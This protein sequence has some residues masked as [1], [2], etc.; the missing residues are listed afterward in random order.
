MSIIFGGAQVAGLV[1]TASAGNSTSSGAMIAILTGQIIM[2][3]PFFFIITL[4]TKFGGG[5]LDKVAGNIASRGKG[6][7]GGASNASN[8]EGKA[9]L[10]RGFERA[11][12][13]GAK[14][15]KNGKEKVGSS[16]RRGLIGGLGRRYDQQRD[17]E[18]S[19]DGYLKELRGKA[20]TD[21]LAS[22]SDY[23][24]KSAAGSVSDGQLLRD[25]AVASA[26]AGELKKALEPLSRAI[27]AARTQ[28][29]PQAM[30]KLLYDQAI[31]GSTQAEKSAAMHE[32]SRLGRDE[33]V[34]ALRTNSGFADRLPPVVRDATAEAEQQR[35]LQAAIG[36]NSA[37]LL[38]KAPD[39]VK[40]NAAAA[41]ANAK[42]EEVAGYTAGTGT[43]QVEYISKLKADMD[44]AN[45][46]PTTT[47][48]AKADLKNALDKAVS[49]FNTSIEDIK[50]NTTLQAKFGGDTGKAMLK[51]ASG[52]DASLQ[53]QLT[54]LSNIDSSTGKIRP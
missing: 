29:D 33:V 30:D 54:S 27:A 50:I 19:T 12:Y 48:A 39:L 16:L 7:I 46:D 23:A 36:A 34:N 40:G 51:A 17:S 28:A 4:I 5:N 49:S 18:S 6:L 20:T 45:L 9:R 44:A 32:A 1:I 35:L 41:F 42:G 24:T 43:R 15:D 38:V 13:G 2:V 37:G 25:R 52:L 53:A 3:V 47:A 26:E 31:G 21:R 14:F 22:D 8:K 11:K 10:G